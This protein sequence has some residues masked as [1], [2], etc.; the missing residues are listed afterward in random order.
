MADKIRIPVIVEGLP[1]AVS[2]DPWGYAVHGKFA[3]HTG[4]HHFTSS[5]VRYFPGD[6]RDF[7][8]EA[9]R[10]AWECY[11]EASAW[12]FLVGDEYNKDHG[13]KAIR[14]N[15]HRQIE[16]RLPDWH[17]GPIAEV[18]IQMGMY[19]DNKI[20]QFWVFPEGTALKDA[21]AALRPILR[22]NT[23][24]VDEAILAAALDRCGREAGLLCAMEQLPLF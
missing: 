8:Q 4:Y 17:E 9:Q 13:W 3:S 19:C 7:G 5:E 20:N 11:R 18:L 21:K 14:L 2:F 23:R 16:V 24:L 10:L 12:P 6:G 22:P 15:H 1:G